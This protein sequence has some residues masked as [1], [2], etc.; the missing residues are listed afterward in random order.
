MSH[1]E[2]LLSNQLCFLVYRLDLAISGRY[3]P[4]LA[5]L[6]LTYGQYLAMLALWEHHELEVG[7]LCGTLSLDTGTV[8]PL[9]KRLE[10]A[11]LVKRER[12]RHDE[13]VVMVRLTAAGAALE[14][15]ALGVPAAMA[16]CL[17]ADEKDYADIQGTLRRM[18]ARAEGSAGKRGPG[19][20]AGPRTT[21]APGARA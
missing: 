12:Q 9:V 14:K 18:L 8:S 7:K 2:L 20:P 21:R 6:G 1:P 10:A 5:K 19:V 11:G 4:L 15:K 3:R 16:R 17:V 13:R